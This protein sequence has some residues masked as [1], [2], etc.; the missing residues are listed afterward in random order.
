MRGL[1]Q[2]A[3]CSGLRDLRVA[4]Y[5]GAWIETRLRGSASSLHE[6]APYVGAWIET[7]Y[8]AQRASA[9][10]VAP[11][12]GAWIETRSG[13]QV[14]WSHDVAPY[15]GAWIETNRKVIGSLQR[16]GRTLRGCV[17]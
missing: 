2:R 9:V 6:V 16:M 14:A 7:R 12:V 4:P 15:V 11:Y 17:D 3:L 8:Q 1:K 13:L 10:F 5:V